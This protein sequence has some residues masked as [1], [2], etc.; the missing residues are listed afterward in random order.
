MEEKEV[1][2]KSCKTI[3]LIVSQ[4]VTIDTSLLV[5][6]LNILD[7]GFCESVSNIKYVRSLLVN[8]KTF[9]P[10]LRNLSLLL[11]RFIIGEELSRNM[12]APEPLTGELAGNGK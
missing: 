5:R 9:C 3:N 1:I 12:K 2:P 10:A 8:V 7:I 6:N 4:E 11:E